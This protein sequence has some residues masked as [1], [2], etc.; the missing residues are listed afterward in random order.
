MNLLDPNAG[1]AA[2]LYASGAAALLW[3]Y[4]GSKRLVIR[5]EME[6]TEASRA[7]E[8]ARLEA[9]ARR[10]SAV[11]DEQNARARYK[12]AEARYLTAQALDARAATPPKA[13]TRRKP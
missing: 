11:A 6:Q 10:A 7:H 13:T 5:L 9:E 1:L 12:E 3:S 2:L 8:R 4:Y